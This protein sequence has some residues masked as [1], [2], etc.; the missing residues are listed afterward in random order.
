ME[1]W[2]KFMAKWQEIQE[3]AMKLRKNLLTNIK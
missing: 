3:Q 2:K 1:E